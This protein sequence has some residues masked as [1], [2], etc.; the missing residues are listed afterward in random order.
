MALRLEVPAVEPAKRRPLNLQS[1]VPQGLRDPVEDRQRFGRRGGFGEE[2]SEGQ[3]H[4]L[5]HLQ[6]GGKRLHLMR[7][8]SNNFIRGGFVARL[9]VRQDEQALLDSHARRTWR[10]HERG[11]ALLRDGAGKAIDVEEQQPHLLAAATAASL[12]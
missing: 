1:G 6:S 7:A 5:S 11:A 3:Q 12:V 2:V 4:N 10:F 8:T 9:R